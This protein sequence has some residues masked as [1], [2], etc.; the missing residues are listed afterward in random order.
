MECKRD[1]NEADCSCS[2]KDC[3]RRGMCCECVAFHRSKGQ[4]P[5]CLR[6]IFEQQE[7]QAFEPG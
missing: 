7:T 4:L 2:T 5:S 3:E 6:N 1:Q